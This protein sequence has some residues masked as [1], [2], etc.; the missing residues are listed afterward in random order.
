M[1]ISKENLEMEIVEWSGDFD[2]TSKPANK[3]GTKRM[4]DRWEKKTLRA[5]LDVWPTFP[6][7]RYFAPFIIVVRPVRGFQL[8]RN[9]QIELLSNGKGLFTTIKQ[10]NL[11]DSREHRVS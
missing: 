11:S 6:Y 5:E 2:V 4:E 3:H 1:E 10:Q 8:N 9:E 7:Q